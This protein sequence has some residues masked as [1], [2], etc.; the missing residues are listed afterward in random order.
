MVS[1]EGQFLV[2]QIYDDE[3]TYNLIGAAVEILK[4]PADDILELFGKTFFEFCQDSGYDKILQV[5]GATPRDFLQV[6]YADDYSQA[7]S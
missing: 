2:R 7:W 4:I 6:N 5:L 1:M 3:I